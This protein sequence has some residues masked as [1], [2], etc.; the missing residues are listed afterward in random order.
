MSQAPWISPET[1]HLM[2]QKSTLERKI[3][4]KTKHNTL[5]N[6]I[7]IS[8]QIESAVEKDL[9]INFFRARKFSVISK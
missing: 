9:K 7:D 5:V 3:I 2:K 4:K 6:L 1:S 8:S